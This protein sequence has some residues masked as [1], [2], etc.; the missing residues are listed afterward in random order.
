MLPTM[1]MPRG[2]LLDRVVE[3][4]IEFQAE[5]PLHEKGDDL[6]GRGDVT[7]QIPWFPTWREEWHISRAVNY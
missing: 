4:C 2:R 5:W 3:I 7:E 6:V 1:P